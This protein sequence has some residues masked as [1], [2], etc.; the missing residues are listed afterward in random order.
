MIFTPKLGESEP[1]VTC[2]FRQPPICLML[3]SKVFLTKSSDPKVLVPVE[4]QFASIGGVIS[5]RMGMVGI[6]MA[7]LLMGIRLT[8]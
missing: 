4:P 8:S 1:I 7:A 3:V 2:Y 5:E 6:G